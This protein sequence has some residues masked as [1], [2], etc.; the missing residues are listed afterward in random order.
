[1][2]LWVQSTPS[3]ARNGSN[4]RLYIIQAHALPPSV[5]PSIR[6]FGVPSF[7][8]IASCSRSHSPVSFRMM[9]LFL[10]AAVT[11]SLHPER[12]QRWPRCWPHLTC[13]YAWAKIK[14]AQVARQPAGAARL[15]VLA[16]AR[17]NPPGHWCC[18]RAAPGRGCWGPEFPVGSHDNRSHQPP[19]HRSQ[20]AQLLCCIFRFSFGRQFEQHKIF[21]VSL[22][23][24]DY[25]VPFTP[26]HALRPTSRLPVW[27]RCSPSV[28]AST[29][30]H[31]SGT[32]T[33]RLKPPTCT[34]LAKVKFLPNL[35][36]LVR[37]TLFV[38]YPAP[39]K[40]G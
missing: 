27:Q 15:P 33:S 23:A 30:G 7:R 36:Q 40:N 12:C 2:S 28:T 22:A 8:F 31:I 10:A 24:D 29:W 32:P 4:R 20:P 25:R 16:R 1:M 3:P 6:P 11:Q 19:P 9:T 37:L 17:Q 39:I 38:I 35:W 21:K 14:V 18:P 5:R 13:N 34:T 26:R